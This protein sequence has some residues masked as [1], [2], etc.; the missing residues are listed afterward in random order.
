MPLDEV[1]RRVRERNAG[2]RTLRGNGSITVESPEGG[3]NGSFEAS[4]RKPDSMLV[5]F[6]GPFGIHFAT[7][8]LSREQ[9]LFYNRMENKAIVGKPDGSV[10]QSMFKLKMQFD[11]ILNAFTGEFPPAGAADSLERFTVHDDQ[12]VIAYKSDGGAKEYRVDGDAFVVTSYRVLDADSS[13]IMYSSAS[14]LEPADERVMPRLLRVV[15]PKERRS[16]TIAYD[17]IE[18]N[19]PVGCSF[20]LPKQAEV[21]SR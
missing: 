19:G 1:L 16:V 5:E 2:V 11:E 18:I 17:D 7:L 15:F 14:E 21:I 10:L 4:L 9:F 3:Q 20:T 13:A 6:R 12:Y 8:S